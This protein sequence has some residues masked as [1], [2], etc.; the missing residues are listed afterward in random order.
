MTLTFVDRDATTPED[1][2]AELVPLGLSDIVAGGRTKDRAL[3]RFAENLR[4]PDWFGGNLDALY[5]LLDEH[6]YTATAQG[7]P[8]LLLWIPGRK[9]LRDHPRDYRR[10]VSVLRD[11]ADPERP[12]P[13]AGARVVVIHGPEMHGP[14]MHGPDPTVPEQEDPRD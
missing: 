2:I 7:R 8:W 13:D 12:A 3:E 6:A 1:L 14:D 9:L 10:I 4:F 11:V 5:E